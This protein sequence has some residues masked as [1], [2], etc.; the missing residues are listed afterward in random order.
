V[1][2]PKQLF[3]APVESGL[4]LLWMVLG[5]NGLLLQQQLLIGVSKNAHGK[6]ILYLVMF[7][8]YEKLNINIFKR[9]NFYI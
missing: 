8:Q 2:L 1:T 5:G 9:C 3:S 6:R 4:S 7:V